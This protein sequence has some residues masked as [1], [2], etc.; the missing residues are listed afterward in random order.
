VAVEE[1]RGRADAEAAIRDAVR[2]YRE[3]ILPTLRVR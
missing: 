3:R 1:I 2:L